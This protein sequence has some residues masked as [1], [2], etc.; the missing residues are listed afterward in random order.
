MLSLTEAEHHETR[1]LM[2][3]IAREAGN[4]PYD[5]RFLSRAELRDLLPGVGAGVVSA[6]Y[7]PYDG[8]ANPLYLLRALH[9]GIA[10]FGGRYL[11]N[12]AVQE[13]RASEKGVTVATPAGTY[14]APRAVIAAGLATRELARQVG[15][16][17]P[18]EPS[19]GQ[20][21]VTERTT[22]RVPLPTNLV[23]Q[24]REGSMMLGYTVDD[25]GFDI[26]TRIDRSRN[27]AAGALKAF[28]FLRD[29]R[30]VRTWAALRVMT[31]DGVPIYDR[32]VSHAGVTVTA[33]HSGVTLAAAHALEVAPWIAGAP[34]PAM[35]ERFSTRRFHVPTAA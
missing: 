13:I 32:S 5:T 1:D 6:C 18:I 16:E 22:D 28:P 19:H 3:A 21:M 33:C 17:A 27:V 26:R 15:L 25:F 11:A 12:H 30:V 9:S 34:M 4:Q 24:T 10:A 23:R 31:A 7:S 8:H 14:R 2:A 29:L 35:L 20:I